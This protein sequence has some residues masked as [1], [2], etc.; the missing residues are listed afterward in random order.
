MELLDK[1]HRPAPAHRKAADAGRVESR[2]IHQ[3]PL[4]LRNP[5]AHK[6]RARHRGKAKE[7][8]QPM[9]EFAL[10]KAILDVGLTNIE[11]IVIPK[12][13]LGQGGDGTKIDMGR[14]LERQVHLPAVQHEPQL[15][16]FLPHE[17]A[18][19]KT[20]A[21]RRPSKD[22]GVQKL[23]EEAHVDLA[24]PK[25]RILVGLDLGK[26]FEI[27]AGV[28]ETLQ[29]VFFKISQHPKRAPLQHG[30]QLDGLPP[31]RR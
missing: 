12:P 3:H 26:V 25:L 19:A 17:E 27:V 8:G 9:G 13:E 21:A 7:T 5:Q 29:Q 23:T 2:R 22:T 15:F 31:S 20:T 11:P 4:H 30:R 10:P 6:N 16:V 18:T 24:G 28:A 1:P 14:V